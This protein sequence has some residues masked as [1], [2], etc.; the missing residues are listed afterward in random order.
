MA[1]L[2][3]SHNVESKHK[4]SNTLRN[5]L[6]ILHSSLSDL[7]ESMT[8]FIEANPVIEVESGFEENFE[9]KLP[10]K[11]LMGTIS[12]SRTE[13]IEALT[14]KHKT[15]F[16]VLD[17]QIQPPL[18]PTPLSQDIALFIIENL[19]ENGYYDGDT[20]KFCLQNNLSIEQFEKVRLRFT[21]IEPVGI[22]SL[23]LAG[24]F[25]FQ[26]DSSNISDKAYPTASKLI[27]NLQDIYS[28]SK[29]KWWIIW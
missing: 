4:L 7:G 18:F 14:I 29:E 2:R 11:V 26:L 17:E 9:K 8:P 28:F 24:S 12:N 1:A 13:Q 19:D 20:Q 16:D 6:P 3:Q 25:L 10:K 21:H 22:A 23:N 5:W 27:T 15:L